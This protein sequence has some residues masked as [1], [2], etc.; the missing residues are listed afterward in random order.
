MAAWLARLNIPFPVG[1]FGPSLESS[2]LQTGVRQCFLKVEG[3]GFKVS[4]SGLG[5]GGLLM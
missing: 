2:Y 4:V 3:L 1:G 5:F